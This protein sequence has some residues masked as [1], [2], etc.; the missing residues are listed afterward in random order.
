MIT[1]SNIFEIAT[2]N[3]ETLG[4]LLAQLGSILGVG[5]RSDG[6]YYLADM[7]QAPSINKWAKYKPFISDAWNFASDVERD[8]AR[9][10][11]GDGLVLESRS[12]D[13]Q[14][15]DITRCIFKHQPPEYI[16]RIRDFDGYN[17]AATCSLAW[18]Q[19]SVSGKRSS[20]VVN[21]VPV[22]SG[23]IDFRDLSIL[24]GWHTNQ[25]YEHAYI[26]ARNDNEKYLLWEG[27]TSDFPS[28]L[29]GILS[30][31]MRGTYRVYPQIPVKT[32]D[33]YYGLHDPFINDLTVE[34]LQDIEAGVRGWSSSTQM[35]A[36]P[37][38]SQRPVSAYWEEAPMFFT[39]G[40]IA[41]VSLTIY[42]DTSSALTADNF[43]L[44]M[45]WEWQGA[46]HEQYFRLL[47]Y[48]QGVLNGDWSVLA[49]SYYPSQFRFDVTDLD[50][51]TSAEIQEYLASIGEVGLGI[52]VNFW[53]EARQTTSSDYER[54][55][56]YITPYMAKS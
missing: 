2:P 54:V 4:A 22:G 36:S 48:E 16:N 51:P 15:D 49:G 32:N 40:V 5:K 56:G 34:V 47:S 37:N 29:S 26:Y 1:D 19:T 8:A 21:T 33:I 23:S 10:E 12:V 9:K 42:N 45:R 18:E 7:C 39:D 3:A 43:R 14:Y 44:G 41:F 35:M 50:F 38:F 31:K 24:S 13:G 27:L 17:H 11:A 30:S 55:T 28:S 52:P 53:I 20:I 25:Q 46:T 6:R